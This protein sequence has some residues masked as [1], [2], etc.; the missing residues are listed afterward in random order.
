MAELSL[1]EAMSLAQFT[2]PSSPVFPG[3]LRKQLTC[4][5]PGMGLL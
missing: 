1:N 2:G 4:Q 3:E 5:G